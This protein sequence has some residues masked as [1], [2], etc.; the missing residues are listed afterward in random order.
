MSQKIQMTDLTAIAKDAAKLTDRLKVFANGTN[1]PRCLIVSDI[2]LES[3]A[4]SAIIPLLWSVSTSLHLAFAISAKP[5]S[6]QSMRQ[7]IICIH[8]A[9][10]AHTHGEM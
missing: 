5:G 7:W 3:S 10:E 2:E 1:V 6:N 9:K 4:A 8:S